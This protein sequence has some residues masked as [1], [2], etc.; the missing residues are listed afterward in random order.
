MLQSCE[1]IHQGDAISTIYCTRTSL[2]YPTRPPVESQFRQ[3]AH[4]IVPAAGSQV[5]EATR[6]IP[7]L[8]QPAANHG[9]TGNTDK[10]NKM[11]T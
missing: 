1:I 7:A 8:C 6:A 9:L 2:Q 3:A 4:A 10:N 5:K 11:E